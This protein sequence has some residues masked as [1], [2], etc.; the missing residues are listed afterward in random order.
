MGQFIRNMAIIYPNYLSNTT[1][2]PFEA[3]IEEHQV[4][5]G[6][7]N[8]VSDEVVQRI[9]EV[10]G[11]TRVRTHG[12]FDVHFSSY[13]LVNCAIVCISGMD[14]NWIEGKEVLR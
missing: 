12:A 10:V 1:F 8:R 11:A 3:E 7:C 4:P 9:Q 14:G 6:C 5:V 2:E 13:R